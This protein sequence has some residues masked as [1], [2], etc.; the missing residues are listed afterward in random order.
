MSFQRVGD[1]LAGMIARW[2]DD[3]E[4]SWAV[5]ERTWSRVAGEAVARHARA[6]S[7]EDGVLTVQVDDPAWLRTLQSMEP[8]LLAGLVAQLGDDLVRGI[9]W[10][11]AEEPGSG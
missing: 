11:E 7:L 9:R 3:P 6:I 5:V 10:S 1:G 8:E 2:I 4:M